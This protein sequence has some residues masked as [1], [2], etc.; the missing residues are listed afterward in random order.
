MNDSLE[1]RIFD[2]KD[3]S[4]LLEAKGMDRS[5]II[6]EI[7]G[8]LEFY[9]LYV[10]SIT[11]NLVSPG[12]NHYELEVLAKGSESD[13]EKVYTLIKEQKFWQPEKLPERDNIYWPTAFMAHVALHT[14]DREGLIADISEIVSKVR[15]SD[16]PIHNGSFIH[17]VGITHNS[18]GS[19]GGTAYF[20][21]RANIAT[22]SKA[23]QDQIETHLWNWAKEHGIEGDLWVRDLNA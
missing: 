19:H 16:S 23:V 7:T 10:A 9:R 6:A 15:E 21:M 4:L 11:F 14:P 17:M 5:G 8:Q 22:Q 1:I 12:Q 20:S 2:T 18:G 13:L 3:K